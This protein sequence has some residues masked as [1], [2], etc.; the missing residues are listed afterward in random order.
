M[1][2]LFLCP[3]LMFA[4]RVSGAANTLKIPLQVLSNP[5]ELASKLTAETQLVIVDLGQSG[6]DVPQI[7]ALVRDKSPSAKIVAFGSHVHVESLAAARAAGCDEVL[8]NSQ[9]DR[10]YVELLRGL[11]T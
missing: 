4:S 11:Q 7:V 8:P 5:G 9:F 2:V 6:L 10:T 3:N 1:A